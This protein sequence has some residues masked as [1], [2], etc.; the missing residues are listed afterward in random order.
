MGKLKKSN[1]IGVLFATLFVMALG[2]F[3]YRNYH[4]PGNFKRILF[5]AGDY[6]AEPI[7]RATDLLFNKHPELSKSVDIIVRTP[8]NIK[9]N[10][11][12][13]ASDILIL[14][15]QDASLLKKNAAYFTKIKNDFFAPAQSPKTVLWVG[16]TS[17]AHIE[18]Q[19]DDLGL[20]KDKQADAYWMNDAIEDLEQMMVYL[21]FKY[22]GY[23]NL[24][25]EKPTKALEAGFIVYKNEKPYKLVASYEEW[26]EFS[27][28]DSTK[29]VVAMLISGAI[30]RSGILNTQTA[31]HNGLLKVNTQPI[32]LFGTPGSKMIKDLILPN[33][34]SKNIK[35]IISEQFKFAD[36][37]AVEILSKLN[38]P[39]LNTI[40]IFGPTI[41]EWK[42]STK[43]LSS[44]EVTWQLAVPE[45]SGVASITVVGG[46][47]LEGQ[48]ATKQPI[49]SGVN[50]VVSRAMRY[51]TL[52]KTPAKN[53]KIA[54]LYWN[55]PP[56]KENV[57][58]SYLN[59]TRSITNVLNQLK[60]QGYNVAGYNQADGRAIEKLIMLRGRN[61]GRYAPGEL[62]R[63]VNEGGMETVPVS[64]YKKWFEQ[65]P[66]EYRNQITNHWGQPEKADIMTIQKNG[67]L[68]FVLPI[69]HLGNV[70]IMPQPD[71][72]RTQDIA[73]LYHSQTLP[74][75]HQYLC[76]Y[77][78]L[79][80]NV[81]ALIY[82]GTHSTHEWLD[83]KE[84]GL[85]DTDSPEVLAGDLPL[86]YIYIM[87]D[88]GEGITAKR[89][90]AATI[91]DHLTPAMAEG[92]LTPELQKIK[93]L[94]AQRQESK[95]LNPDAGENIDKEI[96]EIMQK[97]GMAKD[98]SKNGWPA[99]NNGKKNALGSIEEA[100]DYIAD[101][102]KSSTPFGLHTFG[103]SPKDELLKKF[104]NIITNSNNPAK[105]DMYRTNLVQSGPEELRQLTV[106]LNAHY[107]TPNTGND[108]IRS[109]GSLPSGI[110]FYTFD[111]RTVPIPY[112]D[113]IGNKL[114]N[115]FIKNF[116]EKN[117]KYP[118]KVA[119]EVWGTES[120]RH[121][122]TQEGQGLSMMGVRVKR[123]AKGRLQKLELI[124]RNE[125]KHPRVDVT[126]ST[127]ALYRDNFPMLID[128]LD[129][130]VQM[131]ASSPEA[132]NALRNNAEKLYRKLVA[133][134]MDTAM[135]RKRS[136][137][138]IFAE[139]AGTY[140]SKISEATYAS[141]SW[142]KEDQVAELYIR[143][144]GNGYGGGIWG[145]A[146]KEEYESALSGTQAIIHSRASSLYST[147]DN[148]DFFQFAGAIALGVRH[149]DKTKKSPDFVV[150]DL[151]VKGAEQQVSL[152]RFQGAELRSRYFNPEY[153]KAMQKDGY[154]GA[155][156]IV[157][158]VEYLWGWQ[159]VMPEIVTA[160]KWQEFYEV[161]M[162]DRYNLKTNEFFEENSPHAK[163]AISGRMMEA[164]HKGYW[165]PT[166]EV[167]KDISK[168]YT[169]TVA[170]HGV[171]CGHIT[172]DNPELQ[173]FIKGIAET[174][175][176]IKA[177]D[178]TKW[179]KKVETAT[180]KSLPNA[181]AQRKK[182]KAD[183]KD[184][185]KVIEYKPN[186]IAEDKN[187]KPSSAKTQNVKG[188]VMKEEKVIENNPGATNKVPRKVWI[189]Y[190]IGIGSQLLL[191]SIGGL[192][193]R[194]G[195]KA[196]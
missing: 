195:S 176:S 153:I 130:A 43:G 135:A 57:G 69:I 110:N 179:I 196:K 170:K 71:R 25:V 29:P 149:V 33:S 13:P 62:Q 181:V 183:F 165:N 122:G 129:S 68:H 27:R 138:R 172:C 49:Q 189:M 55:Y 66:K 86:M 8:T 40:E 45:L 1:L 143:R 34:L 162:K 3:L 186:Q 152:E 112:A 178:I 2:I 115:Q 185:G 93:S 139:P 89:R 98:L 80:R 23:K 133:G 12:L 182:E 114:A 70:M 50:K 108:P 127:T 125:L 42:K 85:S 173:Q 5:L 24:Q 92:G 10:D 15:P 124:P 147:L 28:P 84:T 26:V 11:K 14:Q 75:H 90:A 145:E 44:A 160:E 79:H 134:G 150:S 194:R 19:L 166:E 169:E 83:G 136:L 121:Q 119:L 18:K 148:D 174:N 140:S 30:A 141:G 91:V 116:F 96:Y 6:K 65:L 188:F 187:A 31:I 22:G 118:E 111:P 184:P 63:M 53:R 58:A 177:A 154:D 102:E 191:L 76:Q 87:D 99:K 88:V 158:S 193:R 39:V 109:P 82:T 16:K 94:L 144:M 4:K 131:A 105:K 157:K 54:I 72:A 107:I 67:E 52:E 106:G 126:F 100:E 56:G 104:T 59:V 46:T 117:N 78:W 168:I 156:H 95:S 146:M 120:I 142:D 51:V 77:L 35:V 103:L 132:D 164:V 151:R 9:D 64:A 17:G 161:W 37:D 97:T 36:K 48:M 171:S 192:A 167:K 74:P 190:L 155:R 81:D 47:K 41:P 21:L 113:S 101:I 20:V 137:V 128:L 7:I 163:E 61:V 73:A 180:G 123:D 38:I 159:V 32:V 60:T 175:S